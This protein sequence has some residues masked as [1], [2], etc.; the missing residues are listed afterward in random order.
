[1]P[2]VGSETGEL[3]LTLKR[4]RSIAELLIL[5]RPELD[6]P[7]EEQRDKTETMVC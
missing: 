3:L 4:E 6:K 2:L 5:D 1:M 7:R